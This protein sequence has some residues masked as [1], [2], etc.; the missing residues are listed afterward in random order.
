MTEN[1]NPVWVSEIQMTDQALSSVVDL[2]AVEG[3]RLLL[4]TRGPVKL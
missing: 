3:W 4:R 1:L 2:R